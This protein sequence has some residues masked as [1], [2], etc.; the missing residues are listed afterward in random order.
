[1]YSYDRTAA[2][3]FKILDKQNVSAK[4]VGSA[5]NLHE[6]LKKALD[7]LLKKGRGTSGVAY[8]HDK[9]SPRDEMYEVVV[10]RVL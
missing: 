8:V 3:N 5:K 2:A 10:R 1:M 6:G 9:S 7:H 4:P